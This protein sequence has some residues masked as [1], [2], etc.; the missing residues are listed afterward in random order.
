VWREIR[1]DYSDARSVMLASHEPL[2]SR[3]AAH[4]LRC[5]ELL[6][7]FKKGAIVRIDFDHLTVQPRGILKWML[8]PKLAS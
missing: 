7:D 4:F 5:P 6:V 3:C 8:A 2:V 1:A